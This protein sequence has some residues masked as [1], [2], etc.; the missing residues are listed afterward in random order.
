MRPL[1]AVRNAAQRIYDTRAGVEAL[2]AQVA[3]L[4]DL[5]AQVAELA[6]LNTQLAERLQALSAQATADQA[7]TRQLLRLVHDDEPANR[8]R[9]WRIREAPEYELAFEEDEPLVSFVVTTYTN[10]EALMERSLPS[11]LAQTYERFEI[12]IVGDAAAPEIERA[13]KSVRDPRVRF[14]NQTLRGPYDEV[15][16]RLWYV[17][18]GPP[19]NEAL[20]LAR[21]RWVAQMDDDDACRPGRIE[22]LL[23]AARE[24][25]LEFCYGQI[26]EH[27]PDTPDRLVCRFPPALGAVNMQASL[28]H[29]DMRFIVFELGD[30]LF[31]VPGDWSRIRRMMRLG[32]RMGMIDDI[33][34]DYYRGTGWQTVSGPEA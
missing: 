34:V 8:Q 9:L 33:V 14:Y 1:R 17:A 5:K 15:A 10:V 29:R 23:K 16:D 11:M 7:E 30:A 18:G 12:V 6:E 4:S 27:V 32:V 24:R 31:D 3:E 28:M 13:V 22:L 2:T 26:L 19:A 25:R 20:R 21:G